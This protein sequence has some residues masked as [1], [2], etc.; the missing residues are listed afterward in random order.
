[1]TSAM[2]DMRPSEVSTLIFG[3]IF[4]LSCIVTSIEV[5]WLFLSLRSE[6]SVWL[7]N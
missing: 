3:I 1:M 4:V 6:L 2:D 5:F 7:A